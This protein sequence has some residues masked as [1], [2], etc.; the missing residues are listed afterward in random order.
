MI[1]ETVNN[2]YDMPGNSSDFENYELSNNIG[3][4]VINQTGDGKVQYHDQI[5]RND[6]NRKNNHTI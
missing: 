6:A 3:L 5:L 4:Y 1:D 2:Y